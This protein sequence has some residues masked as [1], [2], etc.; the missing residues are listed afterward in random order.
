MAITYTQE[1]NAYAPS[2]NPLLY[3]FS[4]DQTGQA[5]F[6]FKIETILDGAVVSEDRVF[7]E[8]SN[9]AHWNAS[10]IVLDLM[11]M[12]RITS[13]LYTDMN[14]ISTLQI[15]VTE[16][17]GDPIADGANLLSTQSLTF[18]AAVEDEQFETVD[19]DT[20]YRNTKWLTDVP[21]N[22][23]TVMIGQDVICSM[24]SGTTEDYTINFYD[25]TGSILDTH[26]ENDTVNLV[27][28][29]LNDTNL[30]AVYGGLDFDDVASFDI[31]VGTSEVLTFVYQKEICWYLS[32]MLWVNNYGTYDTYLVEHNNRERVNLDAMSWRKSYGQWDG[33]S[34]EY[35]RQSSGYKDFVKDKKRSG[36][37]ITDYMTTL[38]QNWLVTLY[39][40]PEHFLYDSTGLLFP[41][42]VTNS[43]YELKQARFDE[44]VDEKIEY[45]QSTT[46]RSIKL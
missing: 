5:N 36:T 45:Q 26:V 12:P 42:R 13:A 25:V 10:P 14:T 16:S 35:N 19:Y 46:K 7:P 34:Y 22:E 24:L 44:L 39:E 31:Q 37:L 27:Q 9:Y 32:S 2:D 20:D 33:T 38:T 28:F 40:S 43:S 15:R 3:V 17:Y 30:K 6:S 1:P 23:F 11:N 41:F 21:N 18:K 4:S 29:N 8:R